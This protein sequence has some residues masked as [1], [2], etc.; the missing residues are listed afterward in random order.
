MFGLDAV[1][2]L[3]PAVVEQ[4]YSRGLYP[5]IAAGLGTLT[6]WAPFS[7]A[8]ALL[9]GCLGAFP[10]GIRALVRRLRE[11]ETSRARRL[12]SLLGKT[13]ATC[14]AG[15]GVFLLVWGLN[16]RRL[17][18]ATLAGMEMRPATAAELRSACETLVR[19]S[20]ALR[21][22]LGED[23]AG[24]MRLAGGR[25]EALARAAAGFAQAGESQPALRLRTS[26]PKPVFFST[27]L[28]YLGIAG[29]YVPFTAEANVNG[30]VPDPDLPFNA[31]HELA[32]SQGFAREDEANYLGYL[33]CR[34]HA[35]RDFRYSG[36][37][38]ASLYAQAALAGEDREAYRA[39]E[40]RRSPAVRR[41]VGALRAWSERYRGRVSRASRAVNHA[42]L[43]SQGQADGVRSYGRMV[44]LILAERRPPSPGLPT[45]PEAPPPR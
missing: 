23:A 30:T 11:P 24:V 32:H 25:A 44:D 8:E 36:L 14:A 1:S 15:Y 3:H 18:Y 29:I 39:L 6:G 9:L 40:D 45:G 4:L 28:S 27:P 12:W 35:D 31:S 42:Y 38:A 34:L 13:L 21:E 5:R 7:V 22:G 26:S 2:R 20:N 43:R 33:A 37:L 19:E 17:P 16:Y 10:F 41:D